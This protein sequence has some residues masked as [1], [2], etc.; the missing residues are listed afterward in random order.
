MS[1]SGTWKKSGGCSKM[2]E[3]KNSNTIILTGFNYRAIPELFTS[4][5]R[6]KIPLKFSFYADR[7]EYT[8]ELY[9][10]DE[11]EYYLSTSDDIFPSIYNIDTDRV[12]YVKRV[13]KHNG[14]TT[15]FVSL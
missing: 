8:W 15:W 4:E 13:G 7:S 10:R 14:Y 11:K 9:D 3:P 5:K 12:A 6:R 1:F 2:L